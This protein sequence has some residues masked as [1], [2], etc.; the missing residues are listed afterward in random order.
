MD[1]GPLPVEHGGPVRALVGGWYGMASVKWLTRITVTRRA[2]AGFWETVEYAYLERDGAWRPHARPGGRDAA[3]GPDH[4][5]R[6]W[7]DG[8]TRHAD[9]RPRVRVGG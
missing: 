8:P 2:P 7:R 1:S 6:G 3:Q 5:A 9:P 4:R